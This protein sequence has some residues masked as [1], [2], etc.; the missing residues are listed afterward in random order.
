METRCGTS[1]IKSRDYVH[2]R[3]IRGAVDG[4]VHLHKIR[5]STENI[6]KS[7]QYTRPMK[8]IYVPYYVGQYMSDKGRGYKIVHYGEDASDVVGSAGCVIMSVSVPS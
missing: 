7:S 4:N 8:D 2:F 3:K 5:G 6:F 1:S